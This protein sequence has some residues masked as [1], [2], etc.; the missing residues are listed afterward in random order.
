MKKK[1]I[2]SW[3]EMTDSLVKRVQKTHKL[4]KI[5]FSGYFSFRELKE[6]RLHNSEAF[7]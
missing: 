3:A 5:R 7:F 1:E 4:F 2:E 6:D